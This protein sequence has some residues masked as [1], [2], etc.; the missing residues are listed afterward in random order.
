ML[1]AGAVLTGGGARLAGAADL[2]REVLQMPVRIGAPQGVGGLMDQLGNP[3]FATPIGL[4]LWGAN[5]VG[6]EPVG[7]V[8]GPSFSTWMGRVVEWVRGLFPG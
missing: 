3:A 5:H 7:Y 2:A 4:L 8:A 6:T 1:P